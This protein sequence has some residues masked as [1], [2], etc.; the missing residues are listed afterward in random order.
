EIYD[1]IRYSW[2]TSLDLFYVGDDNGS[3][4]VAIQLLYMNGDSEFFDS[5]EHG[6][7]FTKY[8][9]SSKSRTVKGQ[10]QINSSKLEKTIDKYIEKGSFETVETVT[11]N[12]AEENT[13]DSESSNETSS[14]VNDLIYYGKSSIQADKGSNIIIRVVGLDDYDSIK[15]INV[16]NCQTKQ[17]VQLP[18][19]SEVKYTAEDDAS[20]YIYAMNSNG[21]SLDLSNSISIEHAYTTDDEFIMD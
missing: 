18:V 7:G 21:E 10:M 17:E 14:N 8:I 16:Y 13:Y 11:I 1:R 6:S 12:E 3:D 19:S 2:L 9:Y 5:C 15:S 4:G 20:Y